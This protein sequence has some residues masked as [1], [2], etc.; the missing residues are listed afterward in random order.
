M[1]NGSTEREVGQLV[2]PRPHVVGLNVDDTPE[3]VLRL[4]EEG[5]SRLPVFERDLD[6]IVGI[7]HVK[8]FIKAYLN[9]SSTD[10]RGL[11]RRAPRVP[12]HLPAETLLEAFKRL[13]VHMDV[14]MNEYGGTAGIV[15]L[16]DLLQE[17]VGEVQGEDDAAYLRELEPGVLTV[18][19][20]LLLAD[21]NRLYDL[22]LATDRSE[23]VGGLMVDELGR[24]PVVGDTAEAEGLK[25]T[26]EAVEGL[27][28][29][30]A[31]LFL[32]P[33]EDLPRDV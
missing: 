2:M 10:L 23:T 29:T 9:G 18:R 25:L 3:Q 28:V 31:K 24:P 33:P 6:H 8:D 15:T 19:G 5:Y 11:M 21:L 22:D 7:L 26:V 32:P 14:V 30:R 17:V 4:L 20:D 12:E 1:A 13:K 27:A 16:E